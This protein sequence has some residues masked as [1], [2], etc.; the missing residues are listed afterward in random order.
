MTDRRTATAPTFNA[1]GAHL[2]VHEQSMGLEKWP[3][4]AVAFKK[5]NDNE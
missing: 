2:G 4:P 1:L 5:R 3:I